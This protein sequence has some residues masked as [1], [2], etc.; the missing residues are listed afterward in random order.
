MAREFQ[1]RNPLWVSPEYAE[2][3]IQNAWIGQCLSDSWISRLIRYGTQGAHSHSEMF[4]RNGGDRLDILELREFKGGRRKTFQ[5]HVDQPGRIDVFAPDTD[6]WPHFNAQGAVNA[7]RRLTDE[8]YGWFGIWRMAARRIPLFWRFY[9][10]STSDQLPA[11]GKPIRKPFCSHAV[12]LATHLGGGVDP[13]PRCPH[14]LVTPAQLTYSLFY[15]YQFTIMTPWCVS[16]YG[17]G[18]VEVA[19]QN[20]AALG[21]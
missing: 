11:D 5:F 10:P 7:M 18:I 20:E 3:K 1:I 16:E 19:R 6:R 17:D 8:D 14:Y 12:S 4:L 15:L 13:V 21:E 2:S 9:P